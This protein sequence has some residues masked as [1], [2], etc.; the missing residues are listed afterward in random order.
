MR[1]RKNREPPGRE[2]VRSL[3][4]SVHK[5]IPTNIYE[6]ITTVSLQPSRKELVPA[7]KQGMNRC[8]TTRYE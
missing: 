5:R 7:R 3:T 6:K 2:I 1:Q 4:M 8:L